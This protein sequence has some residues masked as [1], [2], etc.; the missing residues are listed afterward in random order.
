M[1]QL[2]IA[3]RGRKRGERSRRGSRKRGA[4][5]CRPRQLFKQRRW[6]MFVKKWNLL[7]SLDFEISIDTVKKA[8]ATTT[9]VSLCV[10]AGAS[11]IAVVGHFNCERDLLPK[12]C[13]S[14]I[15]HTRGRQQQ[16]QQRKAITT[17]SVR[18]SQ[19]QQQQQGKA[20]AEPSHNNNKSASRHC[21]QSL[22]IRFTRIPRRALRSLPLLSLS[23][24]AHSVCSALSDST[25]HSLPVHSL[26]LRAHFTLSLHCSTLLS[27]LSRSH[28]LHAASAPAYVTFTY[29]LVVALI[30]AVVVDL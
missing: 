16:Q 2:R 27:S 21:N 19:Q 29:D 22:S 14:N 25:L 23:H 6:N 30:D 10:T 12:V 18:A 24:S 26:C 28:F 20:I 7:A 3:R 9:T 4:T 1:Q 5:K 13:Q 11:E 15:D 17:T 8:T